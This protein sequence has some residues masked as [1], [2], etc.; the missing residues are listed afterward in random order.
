MRLRINCSHF[1]KKKKKKKKKTNTEQLQTSLLS[2]V[3]K[4]KWANNL[5]LHQHSRNFHRKRLLL[6]DNQQDE[7]ELIAPYRQN[8]MGEN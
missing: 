8:S 3:G 5:N 4:A 6:Y 1:E 7:E 2:L